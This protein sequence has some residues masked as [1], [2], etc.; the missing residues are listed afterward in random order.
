MFRS[1][2]CW[3]IIVCT[4]M[5]DLLPGS[6]VLAAEIM[7]IPDGEA[8]CL[9][10][11]GGRRVCTRV[12]PRCCVVLRYA[13]EPGQATSKP[14]LPSEMKV[15]WRGGWVDGG[16]G[17]DQPLII[18]PG[19]SLPWICCLFSSHSLLTA[20]PRSGLDDWKPPPTWN[21]LSVWGQGAARRA[22]GQDGLL[23][24]LVCASSATAPV[25]CPGPALRR[26]RRRRSC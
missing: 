18:K 4:C 12:G 25:V 22:R 19:T 10:L 6:R 20:F 21:A 8:R 9:T 16:E 13:A 1:C 14:D 3:N 7:R 15:W 24:A 2:P 23:I 26:R 11:R 5:F 17:A